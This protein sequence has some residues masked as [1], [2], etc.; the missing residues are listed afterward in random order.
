MSQITT[1]AVISQTLLVGL[2]M[3]CTEV[4]GL[5]VA[6]PTYPPLTPAPGDL[7]S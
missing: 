5:L 3:Y 4:G 6:S 2:Q 7:P 1:G